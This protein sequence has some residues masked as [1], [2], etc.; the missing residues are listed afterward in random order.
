MLRGGD[1]ETKLMVPLKKAFSESARKAAIEAR[2]AKAAS[3]LSSGGAGPQGGS[4]GGGT[5]GPGVGKIGKLEIRVVGDKP[6][7]NPPKIVKDTYDETLVSHTA[8]TDSSR[9]MKT[10]DV[11][12]VHVP[13][14]FRP[15][16]YGHAKDML[17]EK[18]GKARGA[19]MYE[20]M[21]DGPSARF[22]QAGTKIV[23]EKLFMMEKLGKGGDPHNHH[24]QG[25]HSKWLAL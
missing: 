12:K 20:K 11:S 14:A 4:H 9:R 15:V 21:I 8:E 10:P 23:A 16:D 25:L 19:G 7:Y 24:Y 1:M 17:S 6:N 13:T 3:K 22:F 5:V 2:R 18:Y